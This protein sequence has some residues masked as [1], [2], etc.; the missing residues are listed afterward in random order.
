MTPND[1]NG[2]PEM[3]RSVSMMTISDEEF[4]ALRRLIYD[5]FGINLTDEKRSLLVGRLQKMLR[6]SKIATFQDYYDYLKTDTSGKAVSDLVNM[7]STNYTY[8]NREKDHFDY[9]SK[10]ALPAICQKLEQ[11]KRKDLRVWCA[12]CSSGEEAYT[13]VMLM[14]EYLGSQYGNWDAGILATDI[15]ERVL[16]TATQGIYGADKVA[17]LPKNLQKYFNRLP[18]GRMQVIDKVRKEVTFRRFNLMNTTFPFKKPFQIIFCRNVMIYFDQ[19]TRNALVQRFHRS[20][21]PE[22]YFFIGHSETLGRDS[23]LF[24]YIMPAAYQKGT[25]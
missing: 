23:Q 11:Q 4:N 6:T 13:L 1:S 21:E 7:V 12:G 5:R 20:M 19:Q 14:H 24:K 18:D 15:S 16:A 3:P 9:F 17:S 8:F 22:G 25:L 10:T 2:V